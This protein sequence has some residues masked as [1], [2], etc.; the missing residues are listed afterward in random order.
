MKLTEIK[1]R[2][3]NDFVIVQNVFQN[4]EKYI[5]LQKAGASISDIPSLKVTSKQLENLLKQ[6]LIYISYS[7]GCEGLGGGFYIVYSKVMCSKVV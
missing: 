5:R 4:G 2:L 6:G 3:D 1:K 7:W